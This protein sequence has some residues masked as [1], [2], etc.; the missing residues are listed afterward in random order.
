MKTCRK[1]AIV[2]CVHVRVCILIFLCAASATTPSPPT[3]FLSTSPHT[4]QQQ[5]QQ[6]QQLQQLLQQPSA[7][8][9][10]PS[11]DPTQ[12]AIQS[13]NTTATTT[14]NYMAT[15]LHQHHSDPIEIRRSNNP[16]T[17]TTQGAPSSY[18]SSSGTAR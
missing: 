14:T 2:W 11:S 12:N 1:C 18:S 3:N 7:S 10:S 8:S 4:F 17:T 16:A 13:S 5:L 15:P 9:S 6:F